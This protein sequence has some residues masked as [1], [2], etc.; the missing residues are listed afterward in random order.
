MMSASAITIDPAAVI[1]LTGPTAGGKSALALALAEQHGG[2][3][4]N[5]DA[6]QLYADLAII[7][8]RPGAEDLNRAPHLLYG[9]LDGAESASA[10][11]WADMAKAAIADVRA[12]GRVPMLVGGTGLYLA[13]LLH[14]IAPVPDIA[15][16]VRAAVRALD[17][18]VAA[19]HLAREDAALAQKLHKTDRQRILRGLEVV[20]STGQSLLAWQQQRVGGITRQLPVQKLVLDVP[21]ADLH[22]RAEQRLWHMLAAGAVAEAAAL[23]ARKLQ[24][25]RPVLRAL[26]VAQFAAIADG[27]MA[28]DAAIAAAATATRQYQKRQLTWLRGQAG[29]WPRVGMPATH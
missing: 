2:S 12:A 21:R 28:P 1:V 19:E 16:D 18:A 4:I 11:R 9:V 24:A 22:A 6:S 5:A 8:A 23:V 29:D 15:A 17:T 26:G 3:I 10:A 14:G 25:D 7:S 27:S 20:R 13:T